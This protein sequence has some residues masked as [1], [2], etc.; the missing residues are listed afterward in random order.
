[1][2]TEKIELVRNKDRTKTKSALFLPKHGFNF[3]FMTL[4]LSPLSR[5]CREMR[6]RSCS[7]F[8]ILPLCNSLLL[9]LFICFPSHRLYFSWTTLACFPSKGCSPSGT[10]CSGVDSPQGHKFYQK[11]YSSMGS[12]SH[13]STGAVRILLQCSPWY[14]VSFRACPP[15]PLWGFL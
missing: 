6:N 1:M 11:I 4:L 12:A 5:N 7:Q 2:P 14:A 9:T 15:V 8:I 10:D 13:R 3:P